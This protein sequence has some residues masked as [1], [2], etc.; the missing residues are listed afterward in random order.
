M[1]LA[2]RQQRQHQRLAAG[3]FPEGV[4][5]AS[6]SPEHLLAVENELNQR[7]RMVLQDRCPA[8]LFATLLASASPSVL[9]R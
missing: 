1:T 7:P 2:A 8:A 9:R 4:T 5:L 3:L 6:H